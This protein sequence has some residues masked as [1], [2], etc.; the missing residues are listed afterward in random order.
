[1]FFLKNTPVKEK[2]EVLRQR[3][4]REKIEELQTRRPK[5]VQEDRTKR[6]NM[7]AICIN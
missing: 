2:R 1:M 3:I 4:L 6:G 7:F 5:K